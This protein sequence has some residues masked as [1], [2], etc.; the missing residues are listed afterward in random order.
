MAMPAWEF[1]DRRVLAALTFSDAAGRTV[2]SPVRV[3]ASGLRLLVK[4]PGE[5]VVTEAP[6]LAAHTAAFDAVPAMPAVG[7]VVVQLDLVPADPALGPRRFALPLPR[8]PDP[9]N[10]A[11]ANSLFRSAEVPLL[12]A[13]S[14]SVT[15]LLAA[16]RVGV[17]RNDD[18]RRIEGALVRLRP[19]GGR[20]QARAL[21]DAAG[22]ALLLVPAVPLASPGMGGTVL[23]DI[24]AD[25]DAVIDPAQVRFHAPEDVM[26]ARAAAAVRLVGLIDPDDVEARLAGSATPPQAVRLA[27]GQTRIAAI[28]WAPP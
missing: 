10:A 14:G 17:R 8:D 19:E 13:P 4:R 11:N 2:Q 6:G 15:G 25:L 24:G 20:P 7:S 28:A 23:P 3:A 1:Q 16:V 26:A 5:L 12:P 27:A 21:T 9:A 18:G 22:D